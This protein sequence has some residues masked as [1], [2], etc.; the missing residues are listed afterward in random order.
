MYCSHT[1]SSMTGFCGDKGKISIRSCIS[2]TRL[3]KCYGMERKKKKK[4]TTPAHADEQRHAAP[5]ETSVS[6]RVAIDENT[7]HRRVFVQGESCYCST[8]PPTCEINQ[9]K[10]TRKADRAV[11]YKAANNNYFPLILNQS[12]FHSLSRQQEIAEL[13]SFTRDFF[14][15]TK[16]VKS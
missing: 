4:Q 13:K 6:C 8:K 14:C 1:V 7:L 16:G 3:I 10:D 5:C 9:S 15:P 2:L 11:K 12:L